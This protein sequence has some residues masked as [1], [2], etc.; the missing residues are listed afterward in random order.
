V[1]AASLRGLSY[2]YADAATPALDGIDLEVGAGLAVLAGGSGSGKST[3]LRV[4][5]GLVPHFH[6][7]H[8]SGSA[9][10]AGDDVL[11]TPTRRLARSTGF[12]FQDPEAQFLG[13]SVEREI[14]F[15]MENLR[16]PRAE[17]IVRVDEA[18]A[19]VAAEHLRHRAVSSLSGG[20][21]QRV[22]IAAAL[23]MRPALLVLDEPTSQL[24]PQGAA[25]VVELARSSADAGVAV[26]IAE[27]RLEHLLGVADS[28]L[29]MEGGRL[30]GPG[31]VAALAGALAAPPQ[32]VRLGLSA[33]WLPLPLRAEEVRSRLRSLRA[34]PL[35]PH[36]SRD[37]AWTLRDVAAGMAPRRPLLESVDIAGGVGEVVV[38]MGPNG[39][40]K[41]TLLRVIAGLLPPLA[42]TVERRPGRCAYLPQNPTALL[43]RPT[44][45]E[46]VGLT[47]RQQREAR[48][49]AVTEMLAA[50][51]LS[52][53]AE[54]HPRELSSGE[55]QRAA[56]AAVLCGAPAV[57]LLDEPTRGM[58]GNSRA[59]LSALVGELAAA[60]T[61]VVLA[62]HDSD[63]AADLADRVIEVAG[64]RVTDLGPPRA[65][66]SGA[67]PYATQLGCLLEGG[68]VTVE[69]ALACI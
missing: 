24:D 4:F 65:A 63:L 17:M 43:H 29:V 60:G 39:G 38:L 46:E 2:R 49:A 47:L 58:D 31:A 68:P 12:V 69:E 51:G 41:T 10:V 62:T 59:A 16:V 19:A 28:M 5:N 8:V 67:S 42:G 21:R 61:A 66:L 37:A 56:L 22:A 32:V 30:S 18:L 27:H 33:A 50:L 57:A 64:G 45:R 20:E 26:V 36:L 1:A 13:G 6:G 23:A 52:A 11:R 34:L 14:A 25:A 48:G 40:G 44:V 53:L 9:T 7:G 3:L 54:R 15:G 35:R 55:R